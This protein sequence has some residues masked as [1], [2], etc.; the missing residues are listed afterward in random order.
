MKILKHQKNL[1]GF[2]GFIQRSEGQLS[3]EVQSTALE[4]SAGVPAQ[5]QPSL[6]MWPGPLLSQLGIKDTDNS[7][8]KGPLWDLKELTMY[9]KSALNSI[10]HQI[11]WGEI[12]SK[13]NHRS[14]QF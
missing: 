2:P 12:E 7:Y 10:D 6:A 5:P 4:Q 14:A 13:F 8:P 9:L 11:R 3:G 1:S